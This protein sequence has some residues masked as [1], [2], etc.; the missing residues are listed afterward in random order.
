MGEINFLR[1]G[2]QGRL[3]E[4]YGILD[5]QKAIVKPIPFSHT[6]HNDIQKK[7][8]YAFGRLQRVSA[9]MSKNFW[10]YLGLTSNGI[11]KINAV[12][13]WLKPLIKN[14][15]LDFNNLADII[16]AYQ[17]IEIKNSFFNS[18]RHT[19]EV[20]FTNATVAD[21]TR[22]QQLLIG[23]YG[24]SG[25]GYGTITTYA[26]DASLAVP[27]KYQGEESFY[28]LILL[29]EITQEKRK[30]TDYAFYFTSADIFFGEIWQPYF[31]HNGYWYFDDP[32]LL[33]GENVIAVY[34]DENLTIDQNQNTI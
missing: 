28:T 11:N 27:T 16:T 17:N 2:Y 23:I 14:H 13:H 1:G 25:K 3:G 4:T 22:Q 9:Q 32:E 19:F 29:S 34:D 18:D 15:A 7:S 24:V 26:E 8:F 10:Q 30:I 5:R 12:A 21:A 31:M 6:P 20:L 33:I